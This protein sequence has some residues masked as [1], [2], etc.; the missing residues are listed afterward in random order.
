MMADA[1][2]IRVVLPAHLRALAEV[3]HEVSVKVAGTV[4][5]RSVLD[6]LEADY[7]RLRG[8][9]RDP[10]TARRRPFVRF[11][12]CAEDLSHEPPDAA[13]PADVV[14]GQEPFLIVGAMAGG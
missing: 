5:Q 13:L 1:V 10:V 6:A 14:S 11:F 8:T 2:V 12:A 4:N 9:I 3:E 7:P